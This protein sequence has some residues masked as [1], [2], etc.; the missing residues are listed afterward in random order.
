[1]RKL[2]ANLALGALLGVVLLHQP[3]E[4]YQRFDGACYQDEV[5]DTYILGQKAKFKGTTALPTGEFY[6]HFTVGDRKV[7]LTDEQ[8]AQYAEVQLK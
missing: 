1:M 3:A 2:G 4:F 7:K 8:M 6:W 5:Q